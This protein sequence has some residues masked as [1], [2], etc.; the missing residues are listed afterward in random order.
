M[1]DMLIRDVPVE[2][3]AALDAREQLSRN[4]Y[5]KRRLCQ[6]VQPE[7]RSVTREDL[8]WCA[9]TISDLA[10]PDVMAAIWH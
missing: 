2:V 4:E 8:E 6:E 1:A 7:G 10:D 5:V 3:I 9:D